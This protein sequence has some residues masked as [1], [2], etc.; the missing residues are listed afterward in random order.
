MLIHFYAHTFLYDGPS[1]LVDPP[2]PTCILIANH[3]NR[4]M[5]SV[6]EA[7]LNPRGALLFLF[8]ILASLPSFIPPQMG[9]GILWS[10]LHLGVVT[11]HDSSGF[12]T[13]K[14][15]SSK[16]YKIRA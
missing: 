6:A 16:L 8:L 4:C 14:F 12:F 3:A 2:A 7:G 5:K 15:F 10:R 1:K 9:E 11:G 13:V